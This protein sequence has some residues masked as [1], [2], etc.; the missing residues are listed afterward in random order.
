MCERAT[1]LS[2]LHVY[3]GLF[4]GPAHSSYVAAYGIDGSEGT[5]VI[6]RFACKKCLGYLNRK[7]ICAYRCISKVYKCI[8]KMCSISNDIPQIGSTMYAS[9]R[10]IAFSTL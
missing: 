9:I 1:G 8:S 10:I 3:C 7:Q 2:S 4:V 6:V 5:F